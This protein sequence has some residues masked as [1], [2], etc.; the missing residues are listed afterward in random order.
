M[1]GCS[2]GNMSVQKSWVRGARGWRLMVRYLYVLAETASSYADIKYPFCPG[3]ICL[4]RF[5]IA[6]LSLLLENNV[7]SSCFSL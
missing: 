4:A 5:E 3:V 6:N 2:S 1:V 7:I